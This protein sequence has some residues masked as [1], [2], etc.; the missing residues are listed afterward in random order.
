[1]HQF[2]IINLLDEERNRCKYV[3]F[4]KYY[5]CIKINMQKS[6]QNLSTSNLAMLVATRKV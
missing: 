6:G 4:K 2:A 3:C 5:C 1:M